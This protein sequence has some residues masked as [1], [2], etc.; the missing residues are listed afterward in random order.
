[1][2]L[3]HWRQYLGSLAQGVQDSDLHALVPHVVSP[4]FVSGPADRGESFYS[5]YLYGLS[6]RSRISA[7][8]F[9]TLAAGVGLFND[10]QPKR[11]PASADFCRVS[12]H[13]L[14]KRDYI[15]RHPSE[16]DLPRLG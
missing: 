9:I 3:H 14:T 1:M 5:D 13:S 2:V 8:A 4:R 12:V 6:R 11:W 7:E 15:V 16:S 10:S